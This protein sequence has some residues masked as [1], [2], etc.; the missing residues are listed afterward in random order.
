MGN[1]T[2][3]DELK[4]NEINIIKKQIIRKCNCYVSSIENTHSLL[5]NNLNILREEISNIILPLREN[6][7]VKDLG[8]LGMAALLEDIEIFANTHKFTIQRLIDILSDSQKLFEG[9]TRKYLWPDENNNENNN[10]NN[11]NEN[12]SGLYLDERCMKEIRISIEDILTNYSKE[13]SDLDI[14]E[15]LQ[16]IRCNELQRLLFKVG[17][18]I[19]SESVEYFIAELK[20]AAIEEIDN[21]LSQDMFSGE[22]SNPEFVRSSLQHLIIKSIVT[23]RSLESLPFSRRLEIDSAKDEIS[24]HVDQIIRR[25]QLNYIHSPQDLEIVTNLALPE[26]LLE[27]DLNGEHDENEQHNEHE[28]I[29]IENSNDESEDGLDEQSTVVE[30]LESSDSDE[31]DDEDKG[32]QKEHNDNNTSVNANHDHNNHN[33][34]VDIEVSNQSIHIHKKLEDDEIF[35]A[36]LQDINDIS[37]NN[38]NHN[39][40]RTNSNM[41][42]GPFSNS[43]QLK[44]KNDIDIVIDLVGDSQTITPTGSAQS[45]QQDLDTI[46]DIPVIDRKSKR[47][48][49]EMKGRS[50]NTYA[51]I[52]PPSPNNRNTGSDA[53]ES[54]APSEHSYNT[55]QR[56]TVS[57]HQSS[58]D[59]KESG[60]GSTSSKRRRTLKNHSDGH[61]DGEIS[62][63]ESVASS[64]GGHSAKRGTKY[65]NPF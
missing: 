60:D 46:E 62:G 7:Q 26:S 56:K 48:T 3:T 49:L 37:N 12:K 21:D 54:D 29:L 45:T 2:S 16:E 34:Q 39:N 18:S 27:N 36:A 33:N 25:I 10:D 19:V 41:F 23:Q 51:R 4:I 47:K 30:K 8:M 38:N 20:N 1:I 50:R 63:S 13:L 6:K 55:R 44:S 17:E 14:T 15:S 35:V 24:T 32:N 43:P 58:D 31:E 59:N 61:G 57:N 53:D 52:N 22:F 40:N 42:V 5:D 9:I 28:Q 64:V 11:D 65:S